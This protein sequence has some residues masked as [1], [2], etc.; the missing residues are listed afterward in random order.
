MTIQI[1]TPHQKSMQVAEM[2]K[3]I[4]MHAVTSQIHVPAGGIP[5]EEIC[6]L[7]AVYHLP[8]WFESLVQ[9]LSHNINSSRR[10]D[11]HGISN[12]TGGSIHYTDKKK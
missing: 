11:G 7:T 9:E 1:R 10:A 6:I 8:R 5:I 12:A 2:E 3:I 4:N